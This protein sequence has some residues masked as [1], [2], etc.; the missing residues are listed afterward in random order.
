ME[1]GDRQRDLEDRLT[2]FTNK[3]N[4]LEMEKDNLVNKL[5][6]HQYSKDLTEKSYNTLNQERKEL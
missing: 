2:N 3:T 4:E 6:S 5:R 1:T